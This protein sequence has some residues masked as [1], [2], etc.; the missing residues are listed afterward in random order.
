MPGFC[1]A[2]LALVIAVNAA[3]SRADA[4]DALFADHSVLNVNIT[5]PFQQMARDRSEAPEYSQGT[6]SFVDS[7]GASVQLDIRIRPRGKSRRDRDVCRFPPLRLNFRK[8]Q[9]EG[10]L[11]ANQNVLKLVT[12]C[13]SS[14]SF[15]RYVLKEYLAYRI[16]NLLSDVSFKVKLLKVT[17]TDSDGKRKPYERQAFFIEHKKRLAARTGMAVADVEE[18]IDADRLEPVQASIAELFQYLI[19]NTDYSFIAPPPGDRCCHNAVLLEGG[20]SGYL[21][22]PFD[23]D[24]TGIVDP[25]SALPDENLRQSSVRDRLFRGFCRDPTYQAAS[26]ALLRE[27]RGAIEALYENQ[28]GLTKG[29]VKTALRYIDSF[30]RI[31]DSDRDRERR[32]K[33]RGTL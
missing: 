18:Q 17:Y 16:F 7:S 9:V 5:A 25:P 26:L 24:R 29:D 19:S 8:Q 32:L 27:Q 23:L 20:D 3:A 13:Q 28:E 6:L 1:L 11:F 15:D 21:P 14:K 30:Y 33:C 2:A 10:T 22:V 12:H 4:T 31:I